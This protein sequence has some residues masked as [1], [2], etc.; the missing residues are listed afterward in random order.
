MTVPNPTRSSRVGCAAVGH[1]LSILGPA[2][3]LRDPHVGRTMPFGQRWRSNHP[4]AVCS[5]GNMR[6]KSS[7]T[8]GTGRLQAWCSV[9][10]ERMP[11]LCHGS[12]PGSRAP[13]SPT[14]PRERTP[15][16]TGAARCALVS[17]QKVTETPAIRNGLVIW[18]WLPFWIVGHLS[19]GSSCPLTDVDQRSARTVRAA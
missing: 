6:A 18:G 4:A 16:R 12:G 5:S 9:T 10:C 13:R 7:P 2:D 17:S 1:G 14:A 19:V 11:Q 15:H 3:V 8:L